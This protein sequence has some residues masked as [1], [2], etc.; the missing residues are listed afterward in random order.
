[1]EVKS[2]IADSFQY[3]SQIFKVPFILIET[4]NPCINS[5]QPGI[6]AHVKIP[7]YAKEKF[8]IGKNDTLQHIARHDQISPDSLR[9][10]NPSIGTSDTSFL[11]PGQII[12]LPRRVDHLVISK[13]D[14]YTYE[15]MLHD[16][17]KLLQVYP[18]IKH[19][20]IGSSVMG[21]DLI[22]LQIGTGNKKTH[23]NGSFHANEWITTPVIMRF[24]NHYLLSLTNNE[25]I[26]GISS[27]P[28]F[29]N[30]ILSAVPMVNPDGV[31]LVLKN[32]DAAGV[33]KERVLKINNYNEDFSG[34]KANIRGVDL[35]KQYPAQ[36][37][38]EAKRKRNRP[39]PRDYPGPFPLS[40][41]EVIAMAELAVSGDFARIH[42]FHT[43]GEEIYW[44]FN[45]Y[46]PQISE[47]ISNEYAR[48]SGY[49]PVR[50]LDNY[51]G[52]KDWFIQ[53]FQK[54][55]FTLELG[56]G[57]NPLPIEQFP[58][59]YEESLGVMLANLYL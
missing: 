40:E 1:M 57:V 54:P 10:L 25:P 11:M 50:Y 46:E 27:L 17:H 34:W 45:R 35:N 44:G 41:P 23:I 38:I 18:F 43:Q 39:Q 32:S 52:Y 31:D 16:I 22:E 2:R 3:Y 37:D 7:G 14:H 53:K 20:K 48:V 33:Y 5:D 29:L 6:G 12:N 24:I 36:W 51:A 8:M 55:G 59:I 15:T 19:R 4:A 21:K 56:K 30:T 28:L 42:A 49:K 13:P 58:K 47:V 9:L 26:R